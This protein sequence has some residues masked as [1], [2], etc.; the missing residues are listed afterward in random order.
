MPL[1]DRNIIL[2]AQPKNAICGKKTK[3]ALNAPVPRVASAKIMKDVKR[4][5][6]MRAATNEIRKNH[7]T[8]ALFLCVQIVPPILPKCQT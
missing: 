6:I 4:A 1:K 3:T 5:H 7:F 2:A 8:R